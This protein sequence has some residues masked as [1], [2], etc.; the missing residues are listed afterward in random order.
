MKEAARG[1]AAVACLPSLA[2]PGSDDSIHGLT[3]DVWIVAERGS[4]LG[5]TRRADLI[6]LSTRGIVRDLTSG[7]PLSAR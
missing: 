4:Y 6:W 2:L 7:P 1:T 3:V 5:Q